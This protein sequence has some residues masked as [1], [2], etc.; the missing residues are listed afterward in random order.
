MPILFW[1]VLCLLHTWGLLNSLKKQSFSRQ[2][3]VVFWSW[4]LSGRIWIK[5]Q[6]VLLLQDGNHIRRYW[7]YYNRHVASGGRGLIP[8]PFSL[9]T[10]LLT[11]HKLDKVRVAQPQPP[12]CQG[13]WKK[14]CACTTRQPEINGCSN[15]YL[16]IIL[17]WEKDR[18]SLDTCLSTSQ[19]GIICWSVYWYLLVYVCKSPTYPTSSLYIPFNSLH[20]SPEESSTS[21]LLFSR[22]ITKLKTKTVYILS[23]FARR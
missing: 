14:L 3:C 1:T 12:I 9:Q 21:I 4:N 5:S 2:I 7:Q 13:A 6:I 10:F 16:L 8:H 15:R 19:N 17:F 22:D 18:H 11:V 20:W 23:L